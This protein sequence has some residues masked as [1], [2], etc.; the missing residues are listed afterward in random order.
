ML[1]NASEP[2]LRCVDAKCWCAD[3]ARQNPIYMHNNEPIWQFRGCRLLISRQLE[4]HR[5]K[6]RQLRSH[7]DSNGKKRSNFVR[8]CIIWLKCKHNLNCGR[9]CSPNQ[10]HLAV[11]NRSLHSRNSQSKPQRRAETTKD[12]WCWAHLFHKW[13]VIDRT[14]SHTHTLRT[15]VRVYGLCHLLGRWQKVEINAANNINTI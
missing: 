10:R 4:P 8:V 9:Y 12:L 3:G 11:C 14:H 6:A 1:P 15:A 2:Q 13:I 7:D 5:T